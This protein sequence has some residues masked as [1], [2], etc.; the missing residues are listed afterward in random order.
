MLKKTLFTSLISLCREADVERRLYKKD[1]I[2]IDHISDHNI[3]VFTQG[4]YTVSSISAL[5][6]IH[7]VGEIESPS[8]IGEW[9]F[10]WAF[11]K[12]V[13]IVCQSNEWEVYV[14]SEKKIGAI[15][16]DNHDFHE[17]LMRC[18]LA[19]TNERINE[20]NTERTLGYTLVDALEKWT[21]DT[22]PWLLSTLKTTF[23]LTDILWVER[24]QVLHD[25]YALRYR[26]TRGN[27]PVNERIILDKHK[28]EPYTQED[29]YESPY[30][31]IYPLISRDVCYGYLIYTSDHE[32]LP[33]YVTRITLDMAPNC[34]RIIEAGWK[35]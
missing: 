7:E 8:M 19:V 30:A 32:H 34:I 21:F 5:G 2:V 14:L 31:H 29:I 35:K 27:T 6:G 22:I 11:K 12:P 25:V 1:D 17:I 15:A 20:A 33:G 16:R 28:K 9:V 18:C 23:S 13:K 3:Y 26:E 4:W 24:H 10:F